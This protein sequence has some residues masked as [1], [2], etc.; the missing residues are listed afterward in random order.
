M[1]QPH[2][3]QGGELQPTPAPERLT[4]DQLIHSGITE[5]LRE[6]RPID[7]ATARAIAA[8]LH[9]GQASP[10]YALASTGAL[11]DGLTVELDAWHENNEAGVE[12]EPWLDALDEYLDGRA[13][14][15]GPV[16][17]WSDL[18]PS[19]PPGRDGDEP[20]TGEEERP[21]YGSLTCAIGQQ[22]VSTEDSGSVDDEAEARQALFE[23]ISTAGVTT[24]GQVATI[25]APED[26]E[27]DPFSWADAAIWNP[28]KIAQDNL[29]ETQYAAEE[30]D[31]LF[32]EQPDGEIGSVDELGWY[33]LIRHEGQPGGIILRS[34][35]FGFRRAGG[36]DTDEALETLWTIIQREYKQFYEQRDAYERA[37]AEPADSPS[38]HSPRIWVGSLADY[39]AGRLYGVWMDATLEPDELHAAVQFLLHTGYTPSAEE[40]GIFDYEGFG[41]HE[42]SE[43]S[44]FSTVSLV[45]QGIAEYGPAYAAWVD[46]VGDTSGEL[47]EPERFQDHYLGEWDSLEDYVEDVLQETGFY[48]NLDEALQQ[49]PEDLRHYVK[50][51]VEGIAEEWGQGLYVVEALGVKVWVFDARG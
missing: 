16:V 25:H 9:D 12:V 39:N 48:H 45:A 11:V 7:H 6:Q 27:P 13:E 34:D 22:V 10:L 3:Y 36:A 24:L 8:Q 33:G 42:V 18:W 4:D 20:E 2:S 43:W 38:G 46:Y 1:E 23:R 35:E 49:I 19:Q 26:N 31:A 40:W 28:D 21:P 41:G 30:L 5:A 44:S 32:A 29:E 15:P 17:G 50:V 14:Q 37:T 47:L 51:D